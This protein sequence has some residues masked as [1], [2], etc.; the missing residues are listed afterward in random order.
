MAET[1][2][3]QVVEKLDLDSVPPHVLKRADWVVRL[4]VVTVGSTVALV[5][6]LAAG[7]VVSRVTSLSA[8][9]AAA[10][11]TGVFGV[12]WVGAAL[13]RL[14]TGL[15]ELEFEIHHVHE[16]IAEL[17]PWVDDDDD[18]D[19]EAPDDDVP[20]PASGNDRCPCGSG[21]KYKNCHGAK[22]H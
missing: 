20:E 9:Q 14:R 3:E 6:P 15:M 21:R 4:L 11:F 22:S 8:F 19:D 2:P 5:V 13:D 17:V 7:W 1:A 18:D 10:L 12:F 16:S